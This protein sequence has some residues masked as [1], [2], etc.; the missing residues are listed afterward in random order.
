[1][2]CAPA[3]DY[4]V[5]AYYGESCE[6]ECDVDDNDNDNDDDHVSDDES[7]LRSTTAAYNWLN[8]SPCL[9]ALT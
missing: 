2:R 6:S 7:L 4:G 8:L 9:A 3:T 5:D 1:M